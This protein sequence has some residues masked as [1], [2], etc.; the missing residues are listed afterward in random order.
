MDTIQDLRLAA[1]S[2]GRVPLFAA[3][4]VSTL[5]LGIGAN[6]AIFSVSYGILLRPLGLERDQ[7]V[8]V[9]QLH[10]ETQRSDVT[11]LRPNYLRDLRLQLEGSAEIETVGAFMFDSATL[12][13]DGRAAEVP[14][15]ITADLEFYDLLRV[16]PL[17]GRL[18]N[19]GDVVPDQIAPLV[20]ISE[21]LWQSRF[22]ASREIVGQ[23]LEV[24]GRSSTVLGVL[25]SGVP[26]PQPGVDLWKLQ[27]WDLR[28]PTLIGRLNSLAR[29][30]PGTRL[31]SAQQQMALVAR[32]L[33]AD[34]ERYSDY[35]IAVQGLRDALVGS[36]RSALLTA[37]AGVGLILLIA[38]ANMANLLL[39]R[40][41]GREREIAT[42]RALGAETGRVL[43][44]ILGESA[45]LAAAGGVLGTALATSIQQ[46]LVQLAPPSLPRLDAVRIDGTVLLFLAGT[47]LLAG[48][49]FG[50]APAAHALGLDP[51]RALKA[52]HGGPGSMRLRHGLLVVQLAVAV[53]L[54]VCAS[55]MMRTLLELNAVDPG[56][57]LAGVGGARVYLDDDAYPDDEAEAVYF[58]QTLELLGARPGIESVGATSGLPFDPFTI[59]YDLP[60]TLPG[61]TAGDEVTQAFFRSVSEGYFETLGIPLLAGRTFDGSE[62]ADTESVAVINARFAEQAWPG[63]SPLGQSFQIYGGA[64]ELRVVGVVDDVRFGGPGQGTKPEFFLPFRQHTFGAM[65]VVARTSAA[66][67]AT[68]AASAV[69]DVA[70]EIDPRQPVNSTFVLEGLARG[71][72]AT[73]RFLAILLGAFATIALLLAGAGIYGVFSYWV[74]RSRWELG[75]RRALGASRRGIVLLVLHRSL[76]VAGAGL[77]VGVVASLLTS[78]LLATYLFGVEPTDLLTLALVTSALAVTAVVAALL[79]ARRAA[80][81]APITSLRGD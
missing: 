47:S 77:A 44:Q 42:R 64:R 30:H 41:S 56:F 7:E 57:R 16:K 8:V 55:L 52:G 4:A 50:L 73:E 80:R 6:A 20:L 45:L 43:R 54:L 12:T 71:A 25:P 31:E 74:N 39:A 24:D 1:R 32:A 26:L 40:A 70:L 78:R 62:R 14:T 63:R 13:E 15:A 28:D 33:Q 5:A 66:E 61:E 58:E 21:A 27:H 18:P 3:I 46:L 48:L 75:V 9:L 29:L 22:G 37:A 72:V 2:L 36:S 59:D 49:L 19:A 51:V 23:T 76:R 11:G 68:A 17:L 60:Y 69:R 79:P 67:A 65:T 10:R 38:C 81:V 34:Y 35:T 53:T